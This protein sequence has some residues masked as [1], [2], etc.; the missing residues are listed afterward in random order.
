MGRLL[1]DLA[2]CP[3]VLL[4]LDVDRL[5]PAPLILNELLVRGLV[6]IKL[7]ELVALPVR[8]DIKGRN[9]FLTTDHEGAADD[10]VVGLAVNAGGAEEVFARR[11]ETGEET[12][13]EKGDDISP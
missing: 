12:T 8:R 5:V 6:G 4:A 11:F 9:G 7:D 3:I 13:Y 1:E 2:I 10:G